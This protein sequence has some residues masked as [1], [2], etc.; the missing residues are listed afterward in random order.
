[1]RVLVFAACL[2]AL[3]SGA[4]A[5]TALHLTA[6][7]L[8]VD[9]TPRTVDGAPLHQEPFSYVELTIPEHGT[10]FIAPRSFSGA[11]RAGQFVGR[12]L[13]FTVDGRSVRLQS[14][15]SLLG[16][17]EP[18]FAYI[19]LDPSGASRTAG[20]AR[21]T[22]PT[23]SV[24]TASNRPRTSQ[25]TAASSGATQAEAGRMQTDPRT[26]AAANGQLAAETEHL[27]RRAVEL[28]MQHE[29]LQDERQQLVQTVTMLEASIA[30][31][32]TERDQLRQEAEA[33]RAALAQ[34]SAGRTAASEEVAALA[35][36][37]STLQTDA[38]ALQADIAVLAAEVQR[39]RRERTRLGA[40]RD[41]LAA[42]PDRARTT[43]PALPTDPARLR[44][45]LEIAEQER[46]DY[47][48]T[49]AG[50]R[51]DNVA[52]QAR[53]DS[54]A[55]E[56]RALGDAHVRLQDDRDQLVRERDVLHQE[57]EQLRSALLG[58]QGIPAAPLPSTEPQRGISLPGFD[59]RRLQNEDAIRTRLTNAT[60]LNLP[61][62]DVLVLFVTDPTGRV[63]ETAV[64]ETVHPDLMAF[65]TTLVRAMMFVPSQ[66]EGAPVP[67]R[68]QVTLRVAR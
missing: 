10:Y 7:T 15:T 30:Q 47:A 45:R 59:L 5:Q 68:S 50:L 58:G 44:A 55:D 65:A 17:D 66:M 9:G 36:S 60:R 24:S 13:A 48:V 56:L 12:T 31:T 3:V 39:L 1:M 11:R 42:R 64:A 54:L 22:G 21:L 40:E 67:L 52:L 18:V 61:E 53:F 57:A 16:T 46:D 28:G 32:T 19:R 33:R 27:R 34:A 25:Q 23:S 41:D 63:V 4:A 62:G 20:P 51:R 35:N 37:R 26:Q 14:G 38:T 2:F 43:R 8:L 49:I 6:P 29:A